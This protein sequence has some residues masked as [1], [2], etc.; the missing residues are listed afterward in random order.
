M[1]SAVMKVQL[2]GVKDVQRES[3]YSDLVK[4]IV[5]FL[6]LEIVLRVRLIH[7]AE[8]SLRHTDAQHCSAVVLILS[9]VSI[10]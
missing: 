7:R 8:R 9:S 2:P 6:Q 3:S 10:L 4:L 1:R 5:F